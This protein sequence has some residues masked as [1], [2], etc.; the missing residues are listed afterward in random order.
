MEPIN[1]IIDGCKAGRQKEF[2]KLYEM[3]ASPMLAV[4]YRYSRNMV[5]AEDILQEGFIKV[6]RKIKDFKGS[7]SFEG[8]LRRV[9]VNTAINHYKANL[10]HSY[11]DEY[12]DNI[13][14]KAGE[15]DLTEKVFVDESVNAE[16]ILNL[17][18]QLPDG[19]RMVFNMHVLDGLTHK[20]IADELKITESTSKTQLFK[21]RRSLKELL[22]EKY[23]EKI[24][25]II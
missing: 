16:L 14:D 5:D 18:Q 7:G 13:H 10:K 3:Y 19:Y 8:W 12:D 6:F 21:A 9:M 24:R 23:S 11:Q 2:R 25:N 22:S 15:M 17:V 4:C 1:R 20:E